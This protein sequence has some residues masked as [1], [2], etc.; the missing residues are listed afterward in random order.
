[1]SEYFG[2]LR[3]YTKHRQDGK[4]VGIRFTKVQFTVEDSLQL[5]AGN[6]K[7]FIDMCVELCIRICNKT[8]KKYFLQLNAQNT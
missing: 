3:A 8:R 2:G 4:D 1:V 5:A 6:L 7:V